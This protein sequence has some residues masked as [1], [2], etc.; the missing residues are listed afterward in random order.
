MPAPMKHLFILVIA[1]CCVTVQCFQSP[2]PSNLIPTQT[3]KQSRASCALPLFSSNNNDD[4]APLS[5]NLS[6][7]Q[8][9][10]VTTAFAGISLS[11]LGTREVT[12]QD[13]GLWGI[14]P[15]ATYKRK[16]TVMETIV[17]G[18]IWTFD[19]RLG[20]LNVQVP[21]RMTVV[22]LQGGG[23]FV[24][25]PVAATPELVGYI[26]ALE[27]EHGEVK[28]IVL[29]SV[30][31]EHKAYCGVF[32]QKFSN[33]QV[34]V[35]P[36]QYSFPSNL[37]ISWL[38]FP[39]GRTKLIPRSKEDAPADW[40]EFEFRTLGPLISKDG[41]FGE[42]VFFHKPTETLLVT[43]T[44]LEVTDDVPKIFDEDPRPLLFHARDTVT[45]VVE[46]TIDARERGWR[47][48]V[49]FGLFFTPGAINI[50][51]A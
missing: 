44:V 14:L 7:R 15:V 31:I 42:T 2:S 13:Y 29:G 24:Y 27:K 37:P 36:G 49:L 18:K 9:L 21:L 11:F 5:S 20:I 22:K 30:A 17:P 12:P 45:D 8:L 39:A 25:D 16:K 40:N 28:H 32:A 1:L 10:E 41:A 48:I 51:D 3:R 19:Q 33:A 47:R 50:K 23:L 4:A 26:H 35:T 6:R 43:D 46:D 38:G 34:W